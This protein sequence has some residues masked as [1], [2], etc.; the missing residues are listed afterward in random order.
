MIVLEGFSLCGNVICIYS[1]RDDVFLLP[2][3][4]ENGPHDTK[5]FSDIFATI[6]KVT[7]LKQHES[8]SLFCREKFGD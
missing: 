6:F 2:S 5:I 8:L 4:V 7:D 3:P 1:L